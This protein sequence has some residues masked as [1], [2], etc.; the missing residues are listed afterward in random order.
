VTILEDSHDRRQSGVERHIQT[1]LTLCIVALM[2]WQLSTIEE[3]RVELAIL[4][5]R[6]DALAARV[7]DA[8]S[9]RYR[10]ID[11]QRDFALRDKIIE[12]L[13]YRI[14]KIEEICSTTK[15]NN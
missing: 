14:Q 12:G 7:D 10:T 1:I 3:M 9:D 4:S 13:E 6:V 15:A 8:A 5:G 11:S 2:T